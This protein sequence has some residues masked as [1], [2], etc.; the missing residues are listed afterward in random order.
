MVVLA[1][2]MMGYRA[3]QDAVGIEGVSEKKNGHE[4]RPFLYPNGK[5]TS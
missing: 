4:K 1:T 5:A 3:A 2:E